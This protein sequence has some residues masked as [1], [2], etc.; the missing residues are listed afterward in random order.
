[1]WEKALANAREQAEKTLMSSGMK[2]DSIFAISP[3]AFPEIHQ[4]IFGRGSDGD[5]APME[6]AASTSPEKASVYRLA[7]I[8]ISQ[9]VHVIYLISL[10]K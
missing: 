9:S 4:K 2:I 8:D 3:I 1:M 5:A 10:A 7:P 6:A